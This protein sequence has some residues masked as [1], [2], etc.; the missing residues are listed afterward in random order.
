MPKMVIPG[1]SDVVKK[2]VEET[3][4]RA[5]YYESE[6]P[7]AAETWENNAIAAGPNFKAAVQAAD[8]EGRFKGGIKKAGAAKFKRKVTSVGVSRFGPGVTAAK[9]DYDSGVDPY[10]AELA[11]IELKARGPRGDAGNLDRVKTIMDALHKKRLA[12]LAAQVKAS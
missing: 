4:K 9:D 1:K 8:I 6:A 10:L 11:T 2:W 12:L 7:K 3:P 5:T